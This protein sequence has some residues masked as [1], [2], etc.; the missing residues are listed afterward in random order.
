MVSLIRNSLQ[1]C[2]LPKR[3]FQYTIRRSLNNKLGVVACAV[4]KKRLII[5]GV[6]AILVI[7]YVIFVIPNFRRHAEWNRTFVALHAMSRDHVETAVQAF[8]RD[9]KAS[10]GALPATVPLRALV[11]GGYLSTNDI[12]GLEDRD[13][14]VSLSIDESDPSTVLIRVHWT[15]SIDIV[16]MADGSAVA[17]RR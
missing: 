11:S 3:R 5:V 7:A 10:S 9:H 13:A 6:L 1:L 12:R 4:N 2:D 17:L 14:A 15:E 8:S 16:L